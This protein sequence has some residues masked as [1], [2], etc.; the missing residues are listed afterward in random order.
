MIQSPRRVPGALLLRAAISQ[1]RRANSY[2]RS[3]QINVGVAV[4]RNERRAA[5]VVVPT[6]RAMLER[7]FR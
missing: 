2:R 6:L 3:P 1:V 7:T 5:T 4:S